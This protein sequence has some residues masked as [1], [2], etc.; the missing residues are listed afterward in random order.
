MCCFSDIHVTFVIQHCHSV[1]SNPLS[2]PDRQASIATKRHEQ[3]MTLL[4]TT[5][6][7]FDTLKNDMGAMHGRIESSRKETRKAFS[8][9]QNTIRK[10]NR[11]HRESMNTSLKAIDEIRSALMDKCIILKGHRWKVKMPIQMKASSPQI[12]LQF[13]DDDVVMTSLEKVVLDRQSLSN[14]SHSSN[15]SKQPPPIQRLGSNANVHKKSTRQQIAAKQLA[16]LKANVKAVTPKPRNRVVVMP[17]L[18]KCKYCSRRIVVNDVFKKCLCCDNPIEKLTKCP[19]FT[20]MFNLCESCIIFTSRS[21]VVVNKKVGV[22]HHNTIHHC[23]FC[24]E[25]TEKLRRNLYLTCAKCEKLTKYKFRCLNKFCAYNMCEECR[26]VVLNNIENFPLFVKDPKLIQAQVPN[27]VDAFCNSLSSC[28]P[29]KLTQI[30]RRPKSRVQTQTQ[31]KMGHSLYAQRKLRFG[32]INIAR[33]FD[34]SKVD[35]WIKKHNF[36]VLS[37]VETNFNKK[38]DKITNPEFLIYEKRR[39]RE[40]GG[41]ALYVKKI[42]HSEI[43]EVK[44]YL[45]FDSIFVKFFCDDEKTKFKIL[46]SIYCTSIQNPTLLKKYKR[47]DDI[48]DL[49]KQLKT[50]SHTYKNDIHILGDFNAWHEYWGCHNHNVRGTLLYK[51]IVK[52]SW[53]VLSPNNPTRLAKGS[54]NQDSFI[55]FLISTKVKLC[56]LTTLY[57]PKIHKIDHE[58]LLCIIEWVHPLP[59]ITKK[60]H[61]WN[62]RTTCFQ[63]FSQEFLYFFFRSNK[64]V[65][66]Y[67][68]LYK[69]IH[70]TANKYIY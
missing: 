37:V 5:N 26:T 63:Q 48:R 43:L 60:Q 25:N 17:N 3:L 47:N 45:T 29:R 50:I 35:V 67:I 53:D 39:N 46:G 1:S 38:H 70:T 56:K 10:E 2:S 14:S 15:P 66:M 9:F 32:H 34:K 27:V 42:L 59:T 62:F 54:A 33:S 23:R 4:G 7:K 28:E 19:Y 64:P 44:T 20:C 52:S 24:L 13:G 22:N 8:I 49:I 41:I 16:E 69:F 21:I 31:Q 65:N 57:P 6:A 61:I 12:D 58:A 18:L 30:Q 40:G 55:D 36:H 11:L 68:E 51:T